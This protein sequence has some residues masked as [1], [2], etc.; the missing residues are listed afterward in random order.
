MV[1]LYLLSFYFIVIFGTFGLEYYLIYFYVKRGMGSKRD[2]VLTNENVHQK[3]YDRFG[4]Y[5]EM[6]SEW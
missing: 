4:D 3:K 6:R 2:I 1:F 5:R